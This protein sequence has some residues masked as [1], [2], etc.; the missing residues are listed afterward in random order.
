MESMDRRDFL[1]TA[2]L[3]AA[4]V[5]AGGGL[6]MTQAA[7]SGRS[8]MPSNDP[9]FAGVSDIHIH[10]APDCV[11][12]AINELDMA[13]QAKNAGYRAVMFKANHFSCHDRAYL[14]QEEVPG[15]ACFGSLVMNRVHGDRVNTRAAELAIKTTGNLCRCIWMPTLD[16]TYQR[17]LLKHS[18]KG[19]PV[20]DDSG[21][22][23]PEVIRVMEICAEADIIF[24]TG[25]SSATESLVLA[26]KAREV[27]VGKFVVTHANTNFWKM[28]HDQIRACIDL[29]A[30]VEYSFITNLW[31]PGT[32][33]PNFSR[34][35]SEEFV[36]FA[37]IN[38][39]RS[40]ITTDLGQT[41]MP[42]PVDGMRIC[43]TELMKAGM[44]KK[45][46]DF[47]VRTNPARLVGLDK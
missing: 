47:L 24:A 9:L 1:K 12:R 44:A 20:L 17:S 26:R 2:A 38:P 16:A 46:I 33:L 35:S 28:T 8:P 10:A 4:G 7:E 41:G 30:F 3:S 36:S 29:G 13:R 5:L 22:V 27:G 18:E 31:G 43:I 37:Q 23:L 40:F 15:I 42:L 32:G 34:T 25:H 11:E 19:I 21:A 45:D 6:P 14:V 39:E